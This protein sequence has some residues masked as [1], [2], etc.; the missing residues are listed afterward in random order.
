MIVS[1][2]RRRKAQILL[3]GAL[4]I[5]L[6]AIT[7]TWILLGATTASPGGSGPA[8]G[9]GTTGTHT[10]VST[11][12]SAA[13]VPTASGQIV[14]TRNTP[15]AS[16]TYSLVGWDGKQVRTFTSSEMGGAGG[17]LGQ[18][19]DGSRFVAVV[20]NPSQQRVVMTVGGRRL[21]SLDPHDQFL[22]GDD[23]QHLCLVRN[24]QPAAQVQSTLAITDGGTSTTL[25]N[26]GA[27]SS[28]QDALHEVAVCSIT[29]NLVVIL[30]ENAVA[31]GGSL[32]AA[33][34]AIR[35]FSLSP[36]HLLK[37]VDLHQAAATVIESSDG[38]YFAE[39]SLQAPFSNKIIRAADG[40][41]VAS[42]TDR[43]VLGFTGDD[44]EIA[45]GLQTASSAT[46]L[47]EM[48]KVIGGNVV[49]TFPG[50]MTVIHFRPASPDTFLATTTQPLGP[51]P[52][53]HATLRIV[54]GDGSSVP[55]QMT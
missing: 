48:R 21:G 14:L 41:T 33:T 15:D 51:D 22:W 42:V 31:S 35:E 19:P 53:A 38:A 43:I 54:H 3:A 46:D 10:P 27:G 8:T 6:V 2:V 16:T 32:R 4:G 24:P 23:N 37:Q 52:L 47:L 36:F 26:L 40:A 20:H 11:P 5:P 7:A 34:V 50:H 30:D 45:V 13:S 18:S 55:L 17:M 44:S 25:G 1:P 28:E 12:Q 39:E 29:H 9:G 49:A